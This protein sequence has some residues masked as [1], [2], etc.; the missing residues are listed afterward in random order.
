MNY[1]LYT[2]LSQIATALKKCND[3]EVNAE[4]VPYMT[5]RNTLQLVRQSAPFY[6]RTTHIQ[7][8]Q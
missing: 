6:T 7:D 4:P 3:K 1:N 8:T 2:A 5:E